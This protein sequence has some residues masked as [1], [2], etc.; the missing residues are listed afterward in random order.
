MDYIV[1]REIE[2][3]RY[4]GLHCGTRNRNEAVLSTTL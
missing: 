2:T 3:G 1:E 4:Y